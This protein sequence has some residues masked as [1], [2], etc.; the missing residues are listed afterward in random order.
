MPVLLVPVSSLKQSKLLADARSLEKAGQWL[1]A[2]ETCR[3]LLALPL[4]HAEQGEILKKAGYCLRR[5]ATQSSSFADFRKTL[6]EAHECYLRASKEFA[7]IPE[8]QGGAKHCRAMASVCASLAEE[9]HLEKGRILNEARM[10]EFEAFRA[11][12][13]ER[14]VA[15]AAESCISLL[16]SIVELVGIE[17]HADTKRNLLQ[18]GIKACELLFE[19]KVDMQDHVLAILY[20]WSS[21]LRYQAALLLSDADQRNASGDMSLEHGRSA[22]KF[23]L[24]SEDDYAIA[25][26]NIRLGWA[27]DE[28]GDIDKAEANF[29]DALTHASRTGD[30]WLKASAHYGLCFDSYWRMSQEEDYENM[31]ARSEECEQHAW[32]AIEEATPINYSFT[33]AL[34]Y[35][36][37]LAENYHN[38]ARLATEDGMREEALSRST[39]MARKAVE[40]ARCSGSG[41]ALSLSLH[42]LSKALHFVAI[43]EK[44]ESRK[45]A[46]LHEALETRKDSIEKASEST[47][48]FY[49]NLGVFHSYLA[50]IIAEIAEAEPERSLQLLQ[51]SASIMEKCIELCRKGSAAFPEEQKA[52]IAWYLSWYGNILAKLYSKTHQQQLL[53]QARST[54]DEAIAIHERLGALGNVARIR[55]QTAQTFEDSGEL[56][57]A[58]NMYENASKSFELAAGKTPTLSQVYLEY[59]ALMKAQ[60]HAQNARLA[61]LEGENDKAAKFFLKA[62]NLL[63]T[64]TRWQTFAPFYKACS[65]IE[66]AEGSSKKEDLEKAREQFQYARGMLVEVDGTLRENL[67]K[68]TSEDEQAAIGQLI[69]DIKLRSKYCLARSEL[70]E[71]KLLSR[72]L[73]RSKC[74]GKFTKAKILFEELAREEIPEE[75][76]DQLQILVMSCSAEEKLA[77]G[78]ETADPN[79]Y[80]EA[81]Q[82]FQTIRERSRTKNVRALALGHLSY[83]KALESGARY[84]AG[85]DPRFFDQ[86][87]MYLERAMEAYDEAG[88]RGASIWAEASRMYLDAHAYVDKA[89]TALDVGERLRFYGLAEKCLVEAAKLIEDV[90]YRNKKEEVIKS[91][92]RVRKHTRF[93]ISLRDISPPTTTPVEVSV[94]A[95]HEVDAMP[96]PKELERPNVQGRVIVPTIETGGSLKIQFDLVNVGSGSA[97]LVKLEKA[98]P[99][100]WKAA[101][102]SNRYQLID[103]SLNLRAKKLDPL[104]TETISLAVEASEAGSF[105]IKPTVVFVDDLGQLRTSDLASAHVAVL[106]PLT[107]DHKRPAS[108]DERRLAAVM[109]TDLVGY[110]TLAQ[111]NEALAL[112]VLEKQK[113]VLRPIFEKHRG[114][115][116]KTIG[117][118]FLVEFPSALEAVRCAVDIQ[119]TLQEEKSLSCA[120]K[121]I[122]LRIGI[123]VGDIVHREGDV[124]GDAVNIASRVQ[125]LAEPGGICISRQVYDQVWNKIDYEIIE[126]GK[127]ELK[128]VQSPLEVYSI[129]PQ[130]KTPNGPEA[131]K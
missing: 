69:D 6:Q 115:E 63:E 45:R 121:E 61:D 22:L 68:A 29:R 17:A 57:K 56:S 41:I 124:F 106:A 70:E 58:A 1:K 55:W 92:E 123:H 31:K 48:F 103:G 30:H 108:K 39:K 84:M 64:S 24:A 111:E 36:Y 47:P 78:D 105:E 5:A 13:T 73:D 15:D 95:F 110:T 59:S 43:R 109:F 2:A 12:L 101:A 18:E 107:L 46:I 50:R 97:V 3:Q 119:R 113:A 52:P 79:V 40:E 67:R 88:S 112:E 104:E 60:S 114:Q 74:L 42:T 54:F 102:S 23:A 125:P 91:L 20:S 128:N 62:S 66:H 99:K 116:V 19:S 129:T 76:R 16:E 25:L 82:I 87:K 71:G 14:N 90:G 32:K 65:S 127:H 117:D 81:S 4:E 89:E 118:A 85:L 10:N 86:A 93:A 98:L 77:R 38:L 49:W 11:F 83:C 51:E 131:V 53:E 28:F 122:Q 94:A 26:S 37:G 120:G 9:N 21:G 75:E 44:D 130:R 126:L 34:V 72:R 35:A 100:T 27:T 80:A 96:S 33:I 7:S 8:A